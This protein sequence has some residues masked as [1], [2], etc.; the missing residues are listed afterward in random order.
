MCVT[1]F[2]YRG[3]GDVVYKVTKSQELHLM[4]L[5]RL[6]MAIRELQARKAWKRIACNT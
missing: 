1:S 2:C 5:A 3:C 6:H 4:D